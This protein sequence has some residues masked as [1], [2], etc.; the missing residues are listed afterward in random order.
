MLTVRVIVQK[1][2]YYGQC[3][4]AMRAAMNVAIQAWDGTVLECGTSDISGSDT[5]LAPTPTSRDL[6]AGAYGSYGGT[7]DA[8]AYGYGGTRD[9]GSYGYGGTRDAGVYGYGGY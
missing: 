1:N 9:A 5:Q 3:L 7:R 6:P 4:T 2:N 8:G